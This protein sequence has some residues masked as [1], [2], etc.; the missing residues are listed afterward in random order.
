M[1][2]SSKS[3]VAQDVTFLQIFTVHQF[4]VHTPNFLMSIASSV[5]LP[6]V[7]LLGRHYGFTENRIARLVALVALSRAAI[8]IPFGVL[9]EYMGL[10]LCILFSVVLNVAAA[11]QVFF[12]TSPAALTLFTI[13]NGASLGGFFLA[14]HVFVARVISRRYRGR[15]M[16]AMS[17][18]MRWAHVTGPTLGGFVMTKT[19]DVR[20]IL[21]VAA[22]AGVVAT[23]SLL[24][25]FW[26][27]R[28]ETNHTI[29]S[30]VARPLPG[31]ER[32]T[33]PHEVDHSSSGAAV[34]DPPVAVVLPSLSIVTP[35]LSK[36]ISPPRSPCSLS[37]T[38]NVCLALLSHSDPSAN[39]SWKSVENLRRSANSASFDPVTAE[40][41][42]SVPAG[43]PTES[44]AFAVSGMVSIIRTHAKGIFFLGVYVILITALRANRKLM[45]TFAGMK[46]SLTD[47]QLTFLLSLGFSVDAVLFPLGG[48]IMDRC[49]RQWAMLPVTISLATTFGLLSFASTTPHLLLLSALFGLA[50]SLG[51]GLILTLVADRAPPRS[52]PFFGIM[53]M[54]EDLGHVLGAAAVGKAIEMVGFP[55][56]CWGL[57]CTGIFTALWGVILLATGNGGSGTDREEDPVDAPP[58]HLCNTLSCTSL[59]SGE[60][61]QQ[62]AASEQVVRPLLSREPVR[63][64]GA[65]SQV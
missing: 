54:I 24:S 50:D 44:A 48:I 23:A 37:S 26:P 17:G 31:G 64:Y 53:R 55:A 6:V 33:F 46:A 27:Q 35:T 38:E 30:P 39:A 51:C 45:L 13:M 52:A 10:R 40:S 21:V 29:F 2:D 42:P 34:K 57:C 5:E 9:V 59:P 62:E 20:Y 28:A 25:S 7:S 3:E 19:H 18:L 32:L 14:Q 1:L 43:A 22:G 16:A 47:A 56:T 63:M 61:G 8:D 60:E 58:P 4:D 36:E 41:S 49:G 12:F 15:F 65:H 11:L